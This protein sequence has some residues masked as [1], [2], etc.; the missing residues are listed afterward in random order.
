[1]RRRGGYK[2]AGGMMRWWTSPPKSQG[3][4]KD[5]YHSNLWHRRELVFEFERQSRDLG[6]KKILSRVSRNAEAAASE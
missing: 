2:T 6:W 4:V 1:M 5:V 3:N